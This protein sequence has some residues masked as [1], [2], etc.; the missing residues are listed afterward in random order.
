MLR[1]VGLD[2]L[3][4]RLPTRILPLG[5]SPG[6]LTRAAATDLGLTGDVVVAT[7]IIDAHAGGLA[8]IGTQ[9][10][11]SLALIGG[12]SNCH[13]VAS[14]RPLMVRASGAPILGRWCPDTG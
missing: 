2:D 13:M 8:L 11:G 4:T 3:L 10:E 6:V 12:T 1:A 5:S 14:T 7:G 9:P